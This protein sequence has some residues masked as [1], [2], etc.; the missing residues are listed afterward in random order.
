[1]R[2]QCYSTDGN[3]AAA[4]DT[5]ILGLESASTIRPRLYFV[6]IGS[7]A[8]P[9]DQAYNMQVNRFTAPGTTTGVTPRPLD[10][11]DVASKATGHE[12]HTG[13]P[14]KT[15]GL[16]LL[17]F[18]WNLTHGNPYRWT[19]PEGGELIAPATASNGL[20]LLYILVSAGTAV[21]E[22]TFHHS[23]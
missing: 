18:G 12:N 19:A 6:T 13:E 7:A 2:T 15:A 3:Q 23:E 17:S 16:V 22:A 5:S 10:P 1:M 20:V 9:A 4:A 8:T 21:A 11:V 14:T